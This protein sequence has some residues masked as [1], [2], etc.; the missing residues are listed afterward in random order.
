MPKVIFVRRKR[1]SIPS[2]SFVD[3]TQ[4]TGTGP[5]YTFTDHAIGTAASDRLVIVT[6]H[7]GGTNRTVNSVTIGGNAANIVGTA[8]GTLQGITIA[9]RRVTTG[10]TATIVVDFSGTLSAGCTVGVFR[11]VG[12]LSDT[13]TDFDAP[14]GGGDASRSA[15][16]D[17]AANGVAVAGA[18]G[19]STTD[20]WTN[21]TTAFSESLSTTRHRGASHSVVAAATGLAITHNACRCIM[22]AAWR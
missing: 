11:C 5:T 15:T 20:I 21:A 8:L 3:S 2:L 10:T 19:G 6:V 22:A 16:I 9:W 4:D 13:P 17:I 7:Q 14:A 12:Q 18:S 1:V